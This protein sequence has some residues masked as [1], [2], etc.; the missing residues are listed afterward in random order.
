[1]DQNEKKKEPKRKGLSPEL[2]SALTFGM[3]LR[4]YQTDI[5][6]KDKTKKPKNK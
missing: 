4:N 1:M 6:V 2:V 5:P 3:M